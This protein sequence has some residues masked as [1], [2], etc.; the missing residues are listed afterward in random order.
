[1]CNESGPGIPTVCGAP[2]LFQ[3]FESDRLRNGVILAVMF[4]LTQLRQNP[5]YRRFFDAVHPFFW[6]VIWWTFN[7]VIRDYL[8]SNTTEYLIGV[9]WWGQVYVA[10]IGDKLPDPNAYKPIPRTF[11][12][13]TD[14]SWAS[15]LPTNLEG[16]SPFDD[17]SALTNGLVLRSLRRSRKGALT[18]PH[19]TS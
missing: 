10:A 11:R 9:T 6:P 4:T 16:L 18:S 2:Q 7:R 14:A 1:M 17:V 19:N 12:P 13:L 5:F 15:D 3:P 8:A